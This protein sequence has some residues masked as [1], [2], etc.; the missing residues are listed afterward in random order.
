GMVARG[1]GIAERVCRFADTRFDMLGG[2]ADPLPRSLRPIAGGITGFARNPAD[3]F[4]GCRAVCGR[5]PGREHQPSETRTDQAYRERIVGHL[6]PEIA[7]EIA[8]AAAAG[9]V[10]SLV[11]KLARCNPFAQLVE[12]LGKLCSGLVGLA[13]KLRAVARPRHVW[14]AAW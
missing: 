14:P 10:E 11:D 1:G 13:F 12:C 7:H 5:T 9:I 6:S 3:P 2:F 4:G 8:A